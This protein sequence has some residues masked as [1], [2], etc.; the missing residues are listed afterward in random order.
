MR[1]RQFQQLAGLPKTLRSELVVEGLLAIEAN[2]AAIS[3]EM[4]ACNKTDSF[5]AARMLYNIA[6]EEAGKFLVLIDVYR[7]P[8]SHQALRSRQ[9]R[10]AGDHLSKLV[11]AQI[12]DY[13]IASQN[14]LLSAVSSHRQQLYLDGPNDYDFIY[15]NQ[16]LMERENAFYVDL[17]DFEGELKWW[18]PYDL[19]FHH[20]APTSVRLVHAL[21]AS[22][23]ASTA[24]LEALSVAWA[25]FDPHE[26]THCAAWH[27]RTAEALSRLPEREHDDEQC[28]VASWLVKDR[29]PMPMVE[30]D[31]E[32]VNVETETLITEREARYEAEM[33]RDWG[34]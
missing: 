14:E 25:G 13:S 5:R 3:G 26:N 33:R 15:K 2:I 6:R 29:W 32:E 21:V 10:R 23:F 22:G 28:H 1:T 8:D 19:E 30:F 9:F 27:A 18:L 11:Y 17:V 34:E 16:L 4:D 20:L 24:G 12:A 31:V 7:S